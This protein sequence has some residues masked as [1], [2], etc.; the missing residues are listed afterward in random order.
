VG[1]VCE[2]DEM[3]AEY[4]TARGWNNGVVSEAKL[5]ELEIA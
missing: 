3:L 2:L 4:Y 1:H 5:K